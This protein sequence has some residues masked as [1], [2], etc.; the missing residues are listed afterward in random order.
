MSTPIHFDLNKLKSVEVQCF[1]VA[2]CEVAAISQSGVVG[3]QHDNI[4]NSNQTPRQADPL[5]DGGQKCQ[6]V[7]EAPSRYLP[8][9]SSMKASERAFR[10]DAS[11]GMHIKSSSRQGLQMDL[12]L[13]AAPERYPEWK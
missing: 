8:C 6:L 9:Q 1:G 10:F 3:T 13:L 5:V 2:G 12:G 7:G 11:S 4:I